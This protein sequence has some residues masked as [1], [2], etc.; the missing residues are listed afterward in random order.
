MYVYGPVA[1]GGG[2]TVL[3]VP[4]GSNGGGGPTAAGEYVG[5]NGFDVAGATVVDG[6]GNGGGETPGAGAYVG[7]AGATEYGLAGAT[8]G[9]GSGASEYGLGAT[10]YGLVDCTGCT[11]VGNSTRC[12]CDDVASS[13]SAMQ[14]AA[15]QCSTIGSFDETALQL[16]AQ[17]VKRMN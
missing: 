9:L 15:D 7:G 11:G 3:P 1:G 6:G 5:G 2:A 4:Y 14:I 17:A 16:R 10:L 8:Y 12:A 13:D